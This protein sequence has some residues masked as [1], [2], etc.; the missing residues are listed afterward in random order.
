M[1]IKKKSLPQAEEY[2]VVKLHFKLHI[3]DLM[4]QSGLEVKDQLKELNQNLKDLKTSMLTL[5]RK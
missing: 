4:L 2:S 1:S 5:L 3:A